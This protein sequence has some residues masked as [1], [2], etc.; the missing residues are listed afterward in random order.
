LTSEFDSHLIRIP[1][2]T[3]LPYPESRAQ[4]MIPVNAQP[5]EPIA[6]IGSG[7]RFPGGA[8]SPSKLW[9]LL[10]DPKDLVRKVPKDR[11]D[12][13]SFYHPDGT[14]HGRTNAR[15]A[16]LLDQDPYAFDASFF[17]LPVNEV[18]TIDPQHRLMLET[19]Y[20][21]LNSAGL[22]MEDLRGSSTAVYVGMMHRDFLDNQN[23]DLDAMS[24]YAATGTS[25]AML[26]NRVSYF[27]DWHGP[28][29]T[30]DTACSSSLVAV[31]NAIQQLRSGSSK[32][33]IAAGANLILGPFSFIVTSKL[34][35][36]SPTGRCRMWDAGADGYAK[37]EGVA[38]VATGW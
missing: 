10:K 22:K 38:A 16:Y 5:L 1:Y 36:L 9:D 15:Y 19:V 4:A 28:S 24:Q 6:V 14:H 8:S 26:S 37:G 25:A 2:H 27:F 23:Y 20:E 7:C 33:A 34:N 17:S 35:M 18:N 12:I 32:V 3:I 31:H 11:F 30:I 13:D 21:G 29:M